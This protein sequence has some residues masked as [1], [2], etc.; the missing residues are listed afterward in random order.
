MLIFLD[1]WFSMLAGGIDTYVIL[2]VLYH[3][4]WM[5]WEELSFDW[6]LIGVYGFFAVV[7][8]YAVCW[9]LEALF[10]I[11]R[12][13]D[14]KTVL[15]DALYTVFNRVGI[16]PVFS[17]LLFYQLQVWVNGFVVAHGYIPPTLEMLVPLLL[18]HPVATFV[19]YALILDCADYWRHRI[20]HMFRSAYALHALHHAQRQM[21]FWSDDRNHVLDD[22]VA[23]IWFGVVGL[24]IGI[25][26][27]QFP[28]LFLFMRFIESLS[29]ANIKLSFGWLGDRL[30]VSPRFHRL[31]HG[32]RAAGRNSCNY[33]AVFPVWDMMFGT[34]DFSNEYPPTGDRRAPESMATGGYFEQQ[35][36]GLRFFL[37]E[38]RRIKKRRTR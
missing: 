34:A 28:L 29:H 38:R 26:P 16:L 22:V 15:I 4:G 17:F 13:D 31:H 23:G 25:P 10:P 32:L 27:L 7:V 24:A 20:S 6:A 21:S 5:E 8:T 14:R 2:P 37:E 18:G 11:E 30:L 33:G 9:P 36:G 35:L 19:A 12:W 1:R 3:F